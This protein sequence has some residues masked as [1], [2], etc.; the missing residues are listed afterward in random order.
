[1]EK[2]LIEKYSYFKIYNSHNCESSC[3]FL[4]AFLLEAID[5]VL[6]FLFVN[7]QSQFFDNDFIN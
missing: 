1:M 5:F 3:G 2:G 4:F 7:L 6:S